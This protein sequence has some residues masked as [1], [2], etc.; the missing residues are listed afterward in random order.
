MQRFIRLVL[1]LFFTI[2]GVD[3]VGL[4]WSGADDSTSTSF[5][6]LTTPPPLSVDPPQSTGYF[7]FLGFAA[8]PSVDPIKAGFD[9]WIEAESD[10][11]HRFLDYTKEQRSDLRF[12]ADEVPAF[13]AWK[14]PDPI[15]KFTEHQ[16]GYTAA[17]ARYP[18]LINRYAQWL[19]TPF[20]DMGYGHPGSPRA[21]E[22]FVAHRLYLGQGFALN[23]AEGLDR[24]E[25]DLSAWRTVLA[26]AK[27]LPVK[28]LAASVVGDDA[29]LLSAILSQ[30]DLDQRTFQRVATLARP[31]SREERSLRWPIQNEFAK[32]L[33]RYERTRV[34]QDPTAQEDAKNNQQ[35]IAS[36]AG[37]TEHEFEQVAHPVPPNAILRSLVEKQRSL[38]IF[39]AYYDSTIKAT[40][41]PGRT[42]PK[43]HDIANAVPG[44]FFDKF[45]NPFDNF[46][47][48]APEPNW[49]PFVDRLMETDTRLRLAALQAVLRIA[50]SQQPYQAHI[51]KAGP[52][53]Y[54]PFTGLPMIWDPEEGKLYSAGKDGRDDGGEYAVDIGVQ[55][56][57][58]RKPFLLTPPRPR[59]NPAHVPRQT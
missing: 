54:D 22:L 7:L 35:W 16:E 57:Q 3:L 21:V 56:Y 13:D 1:L 33:A 14:E 20:D 26:S 53:Y 59:V 29:H 51:A 44:S 23:A 45:V 19:S 32:G 8:A 38:N 40:E 36:T 48:R 52:N 25:Q 28:V 4:F 30:P 11:G 46:L 34:K 37:M 31:L 5:T 18:H 15:A 42:L 27:T 50:S 55:V 58:P 6:T 12:T 10:H 39:A 47:Y 2:V 17:V 43:L 9:M 41:A 49:K 24:L